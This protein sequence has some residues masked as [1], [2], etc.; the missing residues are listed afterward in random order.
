[1]SEVKN[2]TIDTFL[3][4]NKSATETLLKLGE[5]SNMVNWLITDD[6]KLQKQ[7]G[8]VHINDTGSKVN[9][10]WYGSL[11]GVNHFLYARAGH[12]YEHNLT[13]HIDT[14]IGAIVDAYPTTF[15]VT[16]NTVYIMDGT[17]FYSWQPGGTIQTVTGYSPTVF[18][19]APPTGGGT[20][21]EGMNYLTG[22]KTMKFSGDGSASVFQLPEYAID[23]VD[24]VIVGG[25]AKDEITDYTV[26][27]PNGTVTFVVNPPTGVNNVVITWTKE[28]A[29]ER[30]KITKCRYYGGSFYARFW[31]YGNPDHLN[32]RYCSGVT[33]AGASDP[34]YWPMWTDS[35]VGEYAITDILTQYDK[36]IIFTTG[37]SSGASAWYSHNESY[38][39]PN[40]GI[41]TTLFPVYPINAKVGNVAFGQTRI[42]TNNPFTIWKGVYSWESTYVMNEKN[43]KW[44]SQRIQRDIDLV[45]LTKAITWDWD[46]RG[47]YFL[48]V[49]KK[50]WVYNYR[51]DAW[52]MLELLHEP[53][54]FM[55][56][57]QKL[58]F[59]T[60]DGYIMRFDDGIG[61][62]D[63]E[64]IEAIWD[65]GYYN[66]GAD[67]IR[68]FIQ[69]M[70]IS[71]LP[72]TSTHVDIYLS[73]D[74]D[75]SFRFIKTI[76]YGLSGFDTWDFSNFSFETNFSPQPKNVKLKAKKI[77]YMKLR[78]VSKG[79]D[80][81]VVLSITLP[82]RTGGL[83]KNRS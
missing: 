54:C 79:I 63:G 78:L 67:W 10:M 53:T 5:A 30:Q 18:T 50:I 68:K 73:T 82:T 43:A 49:G 35:D 12:V 41:I 32:T 75:A 76:S 44:I 23:S 33:M 38:T 83:V 57:E 51:V 3:G 6:R 8:Y 25:V 55:T 45:D 42:I 70:F 2:V 37:D 4:V 56:I 28:D 62:F 7:N 60:T 47:L 66:F 17:E 71:I 1:M 81:A 24:L 15:F 65:M 20:I 80:G 58:Y 11:N 22:Q 46:D 48:C 14:D 16:N 69:Q 19:A 61:T 13:T 40:T 29:T 72:L 52:Y 21:L 26:D 64:E 31:L 34:T 39:D 36:Q 59:G 9:G 74:R 27:K 77:D